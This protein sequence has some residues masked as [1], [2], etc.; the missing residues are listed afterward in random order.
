MSMIYSNFSAP[1]W[2]QTHKSGTKNKTLGMS[3]LEAGRDIGCGTAVNSL[4]TVCRVTV[5]R[6]DQLQVQREQREPIVALHSPHAQK[7]SDNQGTIGNQGGRI[8][9][10]TETSRVRAI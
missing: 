3:P 5:V 8:R 10:I 6:L 1:V 4:L 2:Q 9:H 7:V